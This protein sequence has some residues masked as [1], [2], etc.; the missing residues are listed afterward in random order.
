MSTSLFSASNIK[1]TSEYMLDFNY[2]GFQR[3]TFFSSS[4][5]CNHVKMTLWE[6]SQRYS[7]VLRWHQRLCAFSPRTSVPWCWTGGAA[8]V[9]GVGWD[10][11]RRPRQPH[12]RSGRGAR[13][14]RAAAPIRGSG[15]HGRPR[16]FRPSF[17]RSLF[18]PRYVCGPDRCQSLHGRHSR[19]SLSPPHISV[20]KAGIS[21]G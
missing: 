4:F 7:L 5:C 21:E 2:R 1:T 20:G 8:V 12:M 14:A 6:P 11:S 3:K 15:G 19:Q 16:A 9:V 17:V 18:V 10:R 13:G